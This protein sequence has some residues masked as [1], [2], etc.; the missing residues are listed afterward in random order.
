MDTGTWAAEAAILVAV[1]IGLLARA[2]D[3]RKTRRNPP[4]R[5]TP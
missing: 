3:R 5:R 4:D 2:H 1:A